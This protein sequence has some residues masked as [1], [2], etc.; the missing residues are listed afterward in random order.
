MTTWHV[1]VDDFGRCLS[2]TEIH[3]P[4]V[5]YFTRLVEPFYGLWGNQ[6]K[7]PKVNE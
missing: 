5:R 6:P 3:W 4:E 2:I 1:V 7:Q